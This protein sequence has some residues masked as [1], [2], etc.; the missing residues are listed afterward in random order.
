[1]ILA[2]GVLLYMLKSL[3]TIPSSISPEFFTIL[4]HASA[5]TI[6][7]GALQDGT[8]NDMLCV[9]FLERNVW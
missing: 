7:K 4:N 6:F 2:R 8:R 1:V 9:I 5:R 3:E